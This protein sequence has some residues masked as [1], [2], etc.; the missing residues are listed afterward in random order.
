MLE[1][2]PDLKRVFSHMAGP[3][4]PIL[5]GTYGGKIREVAKD[6]SGGAEG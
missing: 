1:I 4:S 5:S 2:I 6:L 3:R